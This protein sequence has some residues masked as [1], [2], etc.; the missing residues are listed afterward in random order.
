MEEVKRYH[1][2]VMTDN[3]DQTE[4]VFQNGSNTVR[5]KHMGAGKLHSFWIF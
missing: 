4:K 3:K 5:S 2:V 1:T